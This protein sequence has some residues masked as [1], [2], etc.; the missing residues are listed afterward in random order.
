ME[1]QTAQSRD[2]APCPYIR[3]IYVLKVIATLEG[4]RVDARHTVWNCNA[5][6]PGATTKR[7]D[8]RPACYYDL[9]RFTSTLFCNS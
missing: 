3:D 4:R 6:K 1:H 5:R 2:I 8:A 9:K 7:A